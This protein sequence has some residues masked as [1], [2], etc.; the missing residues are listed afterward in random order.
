MGGETV[1]DR[2]QARNAVLCGDSVS[3][4]WTSDQT[5]RLGLAEYLEMALAENGAPFT[6]VVSRAR[7]GASIELTVRFLGR[8]LE[9]DPAYVVIFH[10]GCESLLQPPSRLL[11]PAIAASKRAST[12]QDGGHASG[13]GARLPATRLQRLR[14]YYAK[15][16]LGGS[17]LFEFLG[18]VVGV[19]PKMSARRFRRNVEELLEG[20]ILSSDAHVIVVLPYYGLMQDYL[21]SFLTVTANRQ[22]LV[23]AAGRVASRTSVLDAQ[24]LLTERSH[25]LDDGAHLSPDGHR[26]LAGAIAH[27]IKD[28]EG[29]AGDARVEIT[30][31]GA[32]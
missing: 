4:C 25:L 6:R 22:A 17:R 16:L 32:G 27:L 11:T 19:R 13:P 31:Q 21:Q 18:W 8:I 2:Y 5:L 14:G 3:I 7:A 30:S 28:L 24:D 26:A 12:V 29:P 20:M 23:T 15:K 9:M 1:S 10:G